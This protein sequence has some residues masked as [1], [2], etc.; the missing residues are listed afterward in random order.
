MSTVAEVRLW[1]RRIGA[2]ALEDGAVTATFQ[3]DPAFAE[4][5]DAIRMTT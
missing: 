5:G 2:V 4:S 3:Y 1:G